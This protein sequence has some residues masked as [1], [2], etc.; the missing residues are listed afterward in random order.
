MVAVCEDGSVALHNAQRQHYPS[1]MMNLEYAPRH[2]HIAFSPVIKKTSQK[3]QIFGDAHQNVQ[4][5]E[6]D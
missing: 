3:A 6:V 4:E 5:V 2:T 1:K